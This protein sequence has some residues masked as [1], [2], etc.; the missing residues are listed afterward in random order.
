MSLRI[1]PT[2]RQAKAEQEARIEESRVLLKHELWSA[3]ERANNQKMLFQAVNDMLRDSEKQLAQTHKELAV[4]RRVTWLISNTILPRWKTK[5]VEK[6][7]LKFLDDK[8]LPDVVRAE[9]AAAVVHG[10]AGDA[11]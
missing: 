9:A 10:F 2:Q 11:S 4:S 1:L 8:T 3:N 7:A 5:S 6:L